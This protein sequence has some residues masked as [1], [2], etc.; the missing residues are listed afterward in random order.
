MDNVTQGVGSRSTK[1][2]ILVVLKYYFVFYYCFEILSLFPIIVLGCYFISYY[3]FGILFYFVFYL[4]YTW[5]YID[6]LG[7][8]FRTFITFINQN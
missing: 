4:Y 3:Y 1:I 7:F 6:V 5:V 8:V 2:L